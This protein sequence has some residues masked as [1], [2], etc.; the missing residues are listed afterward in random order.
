MAFKPLEIF[1]TTFTFMATHGTL[2]LYIAP[3][4]S[5]VPSLNYYIYESNNLTNYVY[6]TNIEINTNFTWLTTKSFTIFSNGYVDETTQWVARIVEEHAA[7]CYDPINLGYTYFPMNQTI[8]AKS[9]GSC[10]FTIVVPIQ[11]T[12]GNYFSI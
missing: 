2:Q 5:A 9:T 7:N 3:G 11:I 10:T 6:S 12:D 4:L 1:Y 8:R